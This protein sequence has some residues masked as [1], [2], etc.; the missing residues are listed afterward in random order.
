MPSPAD[1]LCAYALPKTI[2]ANH[3]LWQIRDWPQR[4]R[5]SLSISVLV[6]GFN[7]D[8]PLTGMIWLA[9]DTLL[10]HPLH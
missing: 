1:T 4:L 10:L 3:A 7:Q 6:G 9:N 8:F 5:I 2:F